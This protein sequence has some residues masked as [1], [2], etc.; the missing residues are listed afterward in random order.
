MSWWSWRGSTSRAP[1]LAGQVAHAAEVGGDDRG[2]AGQRFGHG[3]AVA[4]VEGGEDG[5]VGLAVGG[6]EQVV[7]EGPDGL[8]GPAGGAQASTWAV[9]GGAV[10]GVAAHEDQGEEQPSR[11]SS[12]AAWSRARWFLRGSWLPT[13]RTMG[14]VPMASRSWAWRRA[15]SLGTCRRGRA[16]ERSECRGRAG[17]RRPAWS[18]NPDTRQLGRRGD[19]GDAVHVGGGGQ[20]VRRKSWTSQAPSSRRPSRDAIEPDQAR[21]ATRRTGRQPDIGAPAPARPAARA[22]GGC[23]SM[24]RGRPGHQRTGRQGG[25]GCP[26]RTASP[27]RRSRGV[28]RR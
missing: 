22:P 20:I 2:A 9:E 14:R 17:R 12:S 16:G 10:P 6:P 5:A 28:G 11:H 18:A 13:A 26:S 7:G 27:F 25:A 8:D 24:A 1:P 23:T 15:A 3:Q 4:F 19:G 21:S